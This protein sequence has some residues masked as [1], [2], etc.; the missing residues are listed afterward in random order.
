M[1]IFLKSSITS[2]CV[3]LW[4]NTVYCVTSVC[5]MSSL[6]LKKW[7]HSVS[8]SRIVTQMF[9]LTSA[10]RTL[11]TER[12]LSLHCSVGQ[13]KN[14]WH[15][16]MDQIWQKNMLVVWNQVHFMALCRVI[17]LVPP[18][19]R[20]L[21][22]RRNLDQVWHSAVRFNRLSYCSLGVNYEFEFWVAWHI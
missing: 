2:A 14:K 17:T 12:C 11:G 19:W 18:V 22:Y 5:R 8:I 10:Y 13:L 7:S 16:Q 9:P 6:L 3:Y 4:E 1:P 15:A 20:Y 21:R